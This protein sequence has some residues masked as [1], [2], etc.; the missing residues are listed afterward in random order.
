M[1]RAQGD[2]RTGD[3]LPDDRP[4]LHRLHR[5]VARG[6]RTLT[7]IRGKARRR[8]QPNNFRYRLMGMKRMEHAKN[9]EVIIVGAGIGGLTFALALD[10]VGVRCRLYEGAAEF[11]P[12]GVGL[13][14]L[15]HAMR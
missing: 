1:D 14:L 11:K 12:L 2:P 15:P 5:A 8:H 10:Q 13:N 9:L 3:A 6:N 4:R 7:A